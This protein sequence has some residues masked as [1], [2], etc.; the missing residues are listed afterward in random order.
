MSRQLRPHVLWSVC[1]P[2]KE[3]GS[4]IGDCD[5]GGGVVLK[6][7]KGPTP[8]E[9]LCKVSLTGPS[10][11]EFNVGGQHES[12]NAAPMQGKW[13]E[14]NRKQRRDTMRKNPER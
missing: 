13:H 8:L 1:C 4:G 2:I 9:R 3:R 5:D 11:V 14:M 7:I 12:Q 6:R 10:H